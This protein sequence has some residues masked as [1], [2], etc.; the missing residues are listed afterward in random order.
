M[1]GVLLFLGLYFAL[2]GWLGWTAY[3]LFSMTIETPGDSLGYILGGVSAAFLCLFTLK[4]LLLIRRGDTGTCVE[5]TAAEEP[6]LFV[7]LHRLADEAGAPRPYRV[8]L[9]GRVNACVFY[10]LSIIN[11]LLPSRKNLEIGLALVN[12]LTLGELKAVLAHEFGHFAQR[13]MAVGRWVYIAHQIAYTLIT[14]RDMFDEMLQRASAVD[15]RIAW[16]AW[17]LRL[18][19]WAIRCVLEMIFR[20]VVLSQRALER[21]MEL[22]A[23]LVA[24]SVTGSD[25]LVH[26]L[27]RFPAAEQAWVQAMNFVRDENREGGRA[28][29]DVFA[30]QTRIIEGLR[31]AHGDPSYGAVPPLPTDAPERHRVFKTAI[32]RPRQMWSTHPSSSDRE[33]NAKRAYVAAPV[34]DR[35]PWSL[36]ADPVALRERMSVDLMREVR[37]KPVPLKETLARLDAKYQHVCFEPQY[38]GVYAE[39]SPVRHISQVGEFY[40]P[41][42]AAEDVAGALEG[43]YPEELCGQLAQLRILEEEKAQLRAL[44]VGRLQAPGGVIRHRGARITRRRLAQTIAAVEAECAAC[45]QL[46]QEH[47]RRC[48][49]AHLAAAQRLG[50]GW[51]EHLRGLLHLLHYADHAQAA[52][53][54]ARAHIEDTLAGFLHGRRAS[55]GLHR[56]LLRQG[57]LLQQVLREIDDTARRVILDHAV[58]ERLHTPSWRTMLTPLELVP[59]TPATLG[60][61]LDVVDSW[62]RLVDKQL[63][64]LRLAA[65]D[66][67]LLAESHVAQCFRQGADPGPAPIASRPPAEYRV[68]VGGTKA[69]LPG[70]WTARMQSAGRLLET[71]VRLLAA[72]AVLAAAAM[73]GSFIESTTVHVVNGLGTPVQVTLG[74][75]TVRVAAFDHV[76]MS[77]GTLQQ[78][79]VTAATDSGQ[80]IEQL[81][82]AIQ[83]RTVPQIYN[84]AGVAALVATQVTYGPARGSAP[85]MLGAPRWS[86]HLADVY[87]RSAPTSVPATH[88][89]D[90][91][92]VL[93]G[94]AREA[95]DTVLAALPDLKTRAAVVAAHARWDASDSRNVDSWIQHAADTLEPAVFAQILEQRVSD[96][97]ADTFNLWTQQQLASASARARI[98]DARRRQAAASP[99]T[100]DLQYLAVTCDGRSEEQARALAI[101]HKRWP[102]NPWV[103]L[104]LG[105]ALAG[106][107]RWQEALPLIEVA[108]IHIDGLRESLTVTSAR[109]QRALKTTPDLRGLRAESHQLASLLGLEVG[110]T[111]RPGA[112]QRRQTYQALE[113]GELA[114]A[115]DQIN[116][117]EPDR[118]RMLRLLAASDGAPS[119]QVARALQLPPDAGIDV[120]TLLPTL[121]LVARTGGQVEP[122]QAVA[123]RVLQDQA[124]QILR[125]FSLVRSGA[126]SAQVEEALRGA[127]PA[128]RGRVYVAAAVLRGIA[129]PPQWRDQAR[130]LLFAAERPYLR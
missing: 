100:A 24:V 56:R 125:L 43:L 49:S 10:D 22:Q 14:E 118:L 6:A 83:R 47:D 21:E 35:N 106:E 128:L 48:R 16:I 84:V 95:P 78:L 8:F 108:R 103:A 130:R 30:L 105:K 111:A 59:P 63:E 104:S 17:L 74:N 71:S 66:Q 25:A 62:V 60:E 121:A 18:V 92:N 70:R 55:T 19:I 85:R 58:L 89:G 40:G 67:L 96:A 46:I 5:I 91:R 97:P 11:L 27:Y 7:F 39:R 20:I 41:L 127:D 65:L 87:F 51:P 32:A 4:S 34:D 37:L 72:A 36:F 88:G 112:A 90:I 94:L 31:M 73:L 12:V 124:P 33:A 45:Q 120:D 93:S 102:D 107:A 76:E 117:D 52:V 57:M 123:G 80:T 2:A 28:V 3:R 99:D 53:H 122:Y 82:V 64:S 98:C 61:W 68:L 69:P 115:I 29:Q 86:E 101:L 114:D 79:H 23:D 9:S 119:V 116:D 54:A 75:Q 26:A 77:I 38:R 13:S 109:L 42:P 81:D 50:R 126:S 15:P 110:W 129:C 44:Q 113:N 1:A